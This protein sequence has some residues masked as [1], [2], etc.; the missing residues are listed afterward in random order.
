M[1]SEIVVIDSSVLK[2]YVFDR[3]KEIYNIDEAPQ[4]INNPEWRKPIPIKIEIDDKFK[5]NYMKSADKLGFLKEKLGL[6]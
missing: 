1:P 6:E 3:I 5:S 4:A 2:K